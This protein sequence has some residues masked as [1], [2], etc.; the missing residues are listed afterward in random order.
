[1]YCDEVADEGHAETS[2]GQQY[3][4]VGGHNADEF[5]EEDEYIEEETEITMDV[6]SFNQLA[7]QMFPFAANI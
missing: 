7:K 1:M 4:F 2:H 3:S 6:E 5:L